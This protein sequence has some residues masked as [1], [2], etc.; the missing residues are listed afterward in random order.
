MD[1]LAT[2]KEADF[3]LLKNKL[4]LA[5]KEGINSPVTLIFSDYQRSQYLDLLW[6]LNM[7]S[8]ARIEQR[9]ASMRSNTLIKEYFPGLTTWAAEENADLVKYQTPQGGIALLPYG[10]ADL[11]LSVK[12]AS[13]N[14]GVFD[15]NALTQYF[16]QITNDP[17][18]PGKGLL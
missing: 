3:F 5:E 14:L 18:K 12:L 17:P 13:L 11:E 10:D 6:K 9:I 7:T 4:D 15:Y 2:K 8:G 1:S 16:T